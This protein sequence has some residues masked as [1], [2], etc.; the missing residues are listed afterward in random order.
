MVQFIKE[1]LTS[2]SNNSSS[3][4]INLGGFIIGSVLLTYQTLKTGLTY[5][6]FGVFMGYCSMVYV[7]GKYVGN[8]TESFG[9]KDELEIPE[10]RIYDDKP[11][12]N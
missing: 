4:V 10:Q 9:K 6:L 12:Y 5:D 8:K 2:G 11:N 1:S 3:R 7:G